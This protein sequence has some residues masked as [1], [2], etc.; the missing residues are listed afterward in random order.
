MAIYD[1][2]FAKNISNHKII[3]KYSH[4]C[5]KFSQKIIQ[6]RRAHNQQNQKRNLSQSRVNKKAP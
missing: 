4:S 1:I 5:S 6:L 3:S 2:L